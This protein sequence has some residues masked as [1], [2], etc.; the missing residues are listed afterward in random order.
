M[1]YI[2]I[3]I[4]FRD[5]LSLI[6]LSR[7]KKYI[8]STMIN[9]PIMTQKVPGKFSITKIIVEPPINTMIQSNTPLPNG[10]QRGKSSYQI[11]RK[12]RF[13]L[14]NIVYISLHCAVGGKSRVS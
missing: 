3:F 6:S 12:Q 2:N 13:T 5:C 4:A 11:L 10:F 14:V 8:L 9:V 7:V 1:I